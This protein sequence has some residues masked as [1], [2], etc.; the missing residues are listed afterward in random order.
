[1]VAELHDIDRELNIH[2]ALDL[3]ATQC[4]GEFLG[5]LRHYLVAVIVE[6]VDQRPDRRIFGVVH[7]RCVVNG[8]HQP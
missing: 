5:R 4:I 3:T 1:M 6:P 8:A 2:V 7:E